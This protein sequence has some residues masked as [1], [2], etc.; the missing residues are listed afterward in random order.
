MVALTIN[1]AAQVLSVSP[2]QIR[3]LI[4]AGRL[5]VINVGFGASREAP[6]VSVDSIDSLFAESLP[7]YVRPVGQSRLTKVKEFF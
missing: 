4:D 3:R 5:K 6:R 1:E 2:S 7:Q